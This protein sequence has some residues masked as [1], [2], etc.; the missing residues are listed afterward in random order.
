M[1]TSFKRGNKSYRKRPTPN[2]FQNEQISVPSCWE[3]SHTLDNHWTKPNKQ[4]AWKGKRQ[5]VHNFVAGRGSMRSPPSPFFH[6]ISQAQGLPQNNQ[7]L[8]DT[9]LAAKK[10]IAGCFSRETVE[11]Y[12]HSVNKASI[13]CHFKTVT[14][15]SGFWVREQKE[16]KWD[17]FSNESTTQK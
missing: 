12:R 17:I 4:K 1:Q 11:I 14:S 2:A 13:H 8:W 15:G 3:L 6:L 10:G 9:P 7:C 5:I 16:N